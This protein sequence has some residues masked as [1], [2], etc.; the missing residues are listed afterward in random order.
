M[1]RISISFVNRNIRY[2]WI[3][4]LL[5]SGKFPHY[6]C[7]LQGIDTRTKMFSVSLWQ[8]LKT[9]GLQVMNTHKSSFAF[10]FGLTHALYPDRHQLKGA[11]LSV[12]IWFEGDIM[13]TEDQFNS[14]LSIYIFYIQWSDANVVVCNDVTISKC[15]TFLIRCQDHQI[16]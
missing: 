5:W 11:D 15:I 10:W 14:R 8:Y 6:I 3:C 9:I 2:I 16:I 12:S 7:Y 4:T 13:M 1:T